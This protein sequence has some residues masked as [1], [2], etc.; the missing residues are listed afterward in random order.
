MGNNLKTHRPAM[1]KPGNFF[2][3]T[4]L[5]SFFFSGICFRSSRIHAVLTVRLLSIIIIVAL[6]FYVHTHTHTTGYAIIT[7][8]IYFLYNRKNEK[9]SLCNG[10]NRIVGVHRFRAKCRRQCIFLLANTCFHRFTVYNTCTYNDTVNN[11]P[12]DPDFFFF[13]CLSLFSH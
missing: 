12:Y 11:G 6:P 3:G 2:P 10:L 7:Y 9:K 8:V 5:F 1:T 13:P 4:L